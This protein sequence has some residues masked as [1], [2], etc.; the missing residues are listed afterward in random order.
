LEDAITYA[1]DEVTW[2]RNDCKE[3]L[4]GYHNEVGKN[5]RNRL[6]KDFQ[7]L[8]EALAECADRNDLDSTDFL[9]GAA[10]QRS[11]RSILKL[12]RH[13]LLVLYA[14]KTACWLASKRP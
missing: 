5:Y 14:Q 7:L 13:R 10:R 1:N 4:R 6:N 9:A 8:L 2:D 12:A 3:K 11:K